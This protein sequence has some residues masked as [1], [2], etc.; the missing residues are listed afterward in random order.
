LNLRCATPAAL[1]ETLALK[2]M[3]AVSTNAEEFTCLNF[4]HRRIM[5]LYGV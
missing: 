5:N 1:V 4:A 3:V 2:M